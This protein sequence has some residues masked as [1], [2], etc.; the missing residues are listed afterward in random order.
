MYLFALQNDV[1]GI[2][3]ATAS[4]PVS[5]RYFMTILAKELSRP[6]FIPNV[7]SFALKLIYGELANVVLGGNNLSNEKILHEGFVFEYPD[8]NSALRNLLR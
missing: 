3:N 8:L 1:S 5:N 6:F 7:P 4:G 2:Y